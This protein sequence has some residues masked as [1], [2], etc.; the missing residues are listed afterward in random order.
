MNIVLRPLCL[1]VALAVVVQCQEEPGRPWHYPDFYHR[2]ADSRPDTGPEIPREESEYHPFSP[3]NQP[4]RPVRGMAAGF[5]PPEVSDGFFPIL[6]E[7]R[8]E[9]EDHTDQS[10][11]LRG[12]SENQ[13]EQSEIQPEQSEIQHEQSEIQHEQSEIES[14]QSEIQHEQSEIQHGESE[15][16]SE[17]SEIQHERSEIQHEESEIESEQSEIQHEQSEIQPGHSEYELEGFESDEDTE[18]FGNPLFGPRDGFL[19]FD[20]SKLLPKETEMESVGEF[21]PRMEE[22][23]H[24]PLHEIIGRTAMALS[25]LSR[26]SKKDGTERQEEIKVAVKKAQDLVRHAHR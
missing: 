3:R 10:E 14:E 15:I 11:N 4:D 24:L 22:F 1:V 19:N 20:L 13:P 21:S 23:F 16:E 26:V 25:S 6:R 17:Q 18:D 9:S 12:Q 7:R 5:F 2:E 8:A